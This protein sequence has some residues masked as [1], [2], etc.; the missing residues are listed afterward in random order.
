MTPKV[1]NDGYEIVAKDR[2]KNHPRNPRRGDLTA[3]RESIRENGFFGALLVQ[4]STGYVLVGN[5]RFRA[6][7]EEGMT[8]FPV[9]WANVDDAR[10]TKIALADNRTSDRATYD[11]RE[12]VEVLASVDS[13]V[14]TAFD[15]K[16]LA[17]LLRATT[18]RDTSSDAP[19]PPAPSSEETRSKRGEVWALGDHVLVCGDSLDETVRDVVFGKQRVDAIVTDPPF[20]I[21][22]SS[23]GIGTD[24]A[25]D[26]M[27][28]PFFERMFAVMN[29][30]LK[31]YAHAYVF[32]DWRSW[33]AIWDACG[34]ARGANR[35]GLSPAN[36]L[37]WDKGSGMGSMYMSS[38]E[39]VGFF[40]ME[41]PARVM[42]G[43]KAGVRKVNGKHNVIR[44]NRVS[45]AARLH[46]ASKPVSMLEEFLLS[47]TDK[48]ET[49]VDL[50]AGS[51]STLIACEKTGRKCIAFEI[52]PAW[53][54]VVITRWQAAT[55]KTATRVAA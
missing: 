2:L 44:C 55:G 45:G 32:C 12:L 23:T 5:H 46:N 4:R 29:G 26:K 38:H 20:A 1:I 10:A 52:E 49:V 41:P 36:L 14:G 48:G 53:C 24:V 3:V 35:G 8:E 18:V 28:R 54:D 9:A 21:F 6:G 27:V 31:N 51:G 17:K 43:K 33:P 25:D 47:S 50:F 11:H 19:P 30:V 13:L 34:R 7:I 15:P 37:V 39:L 16:D 40:S 42:K 22:G